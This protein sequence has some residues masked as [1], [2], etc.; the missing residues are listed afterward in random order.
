M[1]EYAYEQV[2]ICIDTCTY[3][4]IYIDKCTYNKFI[5]IHI[6]VYIHP[7]IFVKIYV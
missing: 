5:H 1:C 2:S 7:Y 4:L 3:A 6:Y